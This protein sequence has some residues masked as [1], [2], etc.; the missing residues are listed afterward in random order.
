MVCDRCKK[1]LHDELKA[2]GVRVASMELG[3]VVLE[4]DADPDMSKINDVITSNGFELIKDKDLLL[5]EKIK[6]FLIS[7]LE[8]L[9]VQRKQKLSSLLAES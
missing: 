9:P 3:K 6:L 4:S 7:M 5:V 2:L 8:E 1:V